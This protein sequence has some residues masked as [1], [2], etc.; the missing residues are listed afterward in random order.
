MPRSLFPSSLPWALLFAV[1][2]ASGCGSGTLNLDDDDGA[3]EDDDDDDDDNSSDPL[4]ISFSSPG[5]GDTLSGDVAVAADVTGGDGPYNVT[6]WVDGDEVG[7]DSDSPYDFAWDTTAA[8]YG[9]HVLTVKVTDSAGDEAEAERSVTVDQPP[10]ITITSP[11]EGAT[12]SGMVTLAADVTDDADGAVVDVLLDGYSFATDFD[13]PYEGMVDSCGAGDGS[14]ILGA[15][16]TDVGGNLAEAE[17]SVIIDQPDL[18]NDGHDVCVDCDDDDPGAYPGAEEICGDNV[19][20]NCDGSLG[21]CPVDTGDLSGRTYT[22]DYATGELTEPA[23]IGDYI[24]DYIGL[25][26]SGLFQITAVD[27]AS[28]R[29]DGRIAPAAEDGSQDLCQPTVDMPGEDGGF[30]NPSFTVGPAALYVGYDGFVVDLEASLFSGD[31][32]EGGNSI[33]NGELITAIDTRYLD[34]YIG[35]EGDTCGYLGYVGVSCEDCNSDGEPYCLNVVMTDIE[36]EE[37]EGLELTPRDEDDIAGDGS[38]G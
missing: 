25:I 27:D 24:G 13:S 31:I 32:A 36:L 14:H 28:E 7:S 30:E 20:Q 11:S 5:D 29:L 23:G 15:R 18:D 38:C 16:V 10:T 26:G 21:D 37:V 9:S 19:D 3:S 12:V 22:L 35:S 34:E 4:E 1:G 2:L 6:L 17:I 33:S 8:A